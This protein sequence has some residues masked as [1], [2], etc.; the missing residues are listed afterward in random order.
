MD[1]KSFAKLANSVVNFTT[2]MKNYKF[3]LIEY[4]EFI[5]EFFWI[6]FIERNIVLRRSFNLKELVESAHFTTIILG[7]YSG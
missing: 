1:T 4:R 5:R 3:H 2:G 6:S 7:Y